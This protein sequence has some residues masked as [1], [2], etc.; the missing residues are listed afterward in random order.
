MQTLFS[1]DLQAGEIAIARSSL[2]KFRA[3][4]L[5]SRHFVGIL[6][7]AFHDVFGEIR[8][9]ARI[10]RRCKVQSTGHGLPGAEMNVTDCDAA[11][12]ASRTGDG[13]PPC[14]AGF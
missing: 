1:P 14:A 7:A 5:R 9:M 12:V 13:A 4:H 2:A 11:S 10:Y 8:H 6:D 3:P